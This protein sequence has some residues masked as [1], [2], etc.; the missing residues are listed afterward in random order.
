MIETIAERESL[1]ATEK[2]LDDRIAEQ[3]EKRGVYLDDG[4]WDDLQK[5][6]AESE[7]RKTT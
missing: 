4:L 3:S 5:L 7:K 6:A 2:D 1:A